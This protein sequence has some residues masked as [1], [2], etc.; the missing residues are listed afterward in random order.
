[1]SDDTDAFLEHYGVMGMHWGQRKEP[2]TSLRTINKEFEKTRDDELERL[3]QKYNLASK[4]DSLEDYKKKHG[5]TEFET[6][7]NDKHV[8]R[9]YNQLFKLESRIHDEAYNKA[10]KAMIE[11]YGKKRYDQMQKV[12]AAKVVTLIT[13]LATLPIALIIASRTL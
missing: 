4:R 3:K 12:Q 11:K 9:S 5:L 7:T 1:M 6:G 10:A 13:G 8:D 2:K